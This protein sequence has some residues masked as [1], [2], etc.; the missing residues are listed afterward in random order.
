M[1]AD[2]GSS[3]TR[4]S[5]LER[6]QTG[7]CFVAHAKA[8]T[9]AEPPWSDVSLGV[10]HAIEQI[11]ETTRRALLDD[12][13]ALLVPEMGGKETFAELRKIDPDV[14]ILLSS[15]YSI[16]GMARQILADGCDGFIQKPFSMNDLSAKIRKISEMKL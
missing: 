5:L 2:C 10:R 14:R 8:E 3:F 7:Y 13:G 9:T 1:V 6:V 11:T 12:T 15:G 4:V 16:D